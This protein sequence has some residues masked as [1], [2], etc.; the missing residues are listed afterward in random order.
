MDYEFSEDK[1]TVLYEGKTYEAVETTGDCK[2]CAFNHLGGKCP[3]RCLPFLRDDNRV[4]I[5]KLK[6]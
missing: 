5:W 4:I 6:N 3:S 1:N 2:D